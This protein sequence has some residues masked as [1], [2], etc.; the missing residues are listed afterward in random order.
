MLPSRSEAECNNRDLLSIPNSLHFTTSFPSACYSNRATFDINNI[1]G[2]GNISVGMQMRATGNS[3]NNDDSTIPQSYQF[4]PSGQNYSSSCFLDQHNLIGTMPPVAHNTVFP[5]DMN[6][7]NFIQFDYQGG[8]CD[9]F[10]NLILDESSDRLNRS[11]EDC[12]SSGS[13]APAGGISKRKKRRHRTIFTQYQLDELEKA[14]K[15]AH[16]PEMAARELLS[17]K[18]ELPEDRI[19]V[20]FQNR[21]AKWR[22]TEKTWGKSTIMA[23]YGLYGAMVRHQLPLPETIAKSTSED[24]DKSAAPWLLG[25]HKKN[26]ETRGQWDADGSEEE[27]EGDQ[28]K[29]TLHFDPRQIKTKEELSLANIPLSLQPYT[30]PNFPYGP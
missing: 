29:K 14:F 25:M 15:V 2:L 28:D 11:K 12:T 4:V 17:Q 21:R 1:L 26:I 22:K 16:Y 30:V 20:W 23:E 10:N 7:N 18:T 13:S 9:N 24:P 19:Q 6:T 3:T 5:L 8:N 27:D